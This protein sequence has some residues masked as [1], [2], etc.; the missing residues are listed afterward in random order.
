MKVIICLDDRDGMMF[1]GRRQSKDRVLNTDVIALSG[2][3]LRMSKYSYA[4]FDDTE[5][6]CTV[7]ED[8]L[9]TAEHDDWCFVEDG[10]L[11]EHA[12]K[13]DTLVVYRWNRH[14]P[15]DK[16]LD[17]DIDGLG[18]TLEETTDLVGHS[19]EKITRE[20]YKK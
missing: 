5:A 16:S 1:N 6:V 13:I 20:I 11:S 15:S 12:D 3:C 17:I 9:D 19:H 14:Y 7:A 8:F 10:T 18:F 2:G 4:M